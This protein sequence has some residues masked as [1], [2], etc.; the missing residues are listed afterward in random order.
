[1]K[2]N[3]ASI[4]LGFNKNLSPQP[5]AN[6]FPLAGKCKENRTENNGEEDYIISLCLLRGERLLQ[7]KVNC[8]KYLE[9]KATKDI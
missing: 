1:M 5:L 2:K 9:H 8:G 6:N 7:R 3:L 4:T